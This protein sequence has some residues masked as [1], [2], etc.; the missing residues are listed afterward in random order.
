MRACADHARGRPRAHKRV[1]AGPTRPNPCPPLLPPHTLRRHRA[2]SSVTRLSGG[3]PM[4][5]AGTGT[6]HRTTA[7]V[8]STLLAVAGLAVLSP[9]ALADSQPNP[10]TAQNPTTVSADGLPTVQVNGV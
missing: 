4:G 6:R 5:T 2:N 9:V 7:L 10:V 8:A 3:R 1:T